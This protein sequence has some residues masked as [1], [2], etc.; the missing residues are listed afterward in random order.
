LIDGERLLTEGWLD[1]A[2]FTAPVD[3][4]REITVYGARDSDNFYLAI[5]VINAAPN[6]S[7]S[8][9]VYFDVDNSGGD[10]NFTDRFYQIGKDGSLVAQAG[11]GTNSDGAGWDTVYTGIDWDARLSEAA[12]GWTVEM[13]FGIQAEMPALTTPFRL[14]VR[15]LFADSGELAIWP[16]NTSDTQSEGWQPIDISTTCTPP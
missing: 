4:T 9:R 8:L 7:D 13:R 12:W 15:A 1:V 16:A 11:D 2:T 3:T 5:T 6:P 10:P 14:S